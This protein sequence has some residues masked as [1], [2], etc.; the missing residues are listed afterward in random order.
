MNP[1][2]APPGGISADTPRVVSRT[3]LIAIVVIVVVVGVGLLVGFLTAAYVKVQNNTKHRVAVVPAIDL[4]RKVLDRR[5]GHGGRPPKAALPPGVTRRALAH[6]PV[7]DQLEG[8]QPGADAA[9]LS[10]LVGLPPSHM[11]GPWPVPV[12]GSAPMRA[13][14]A[15]RDGAASDTT[16]QRLATVVVFHG[17][18][19]GLEFPYFPYTVTGAPGRAVAWFNVTPGGHVDPRT[20]FAFLPGTQ[21]VIAHWADRPLGDGAGASDPAAGVTASRHS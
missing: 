7:M 1:S 8:V 11:T 5:K 15:S 19:G 16:P 9:T 2:D 13:Y 3:A 21:A 10:K 14:V 20:Q 12:D 6:Y 4:H 18:G 17:P